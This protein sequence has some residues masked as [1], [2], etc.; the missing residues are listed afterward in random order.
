[1]N[2]LTA[3]KGSMDPMDLRRDELEEY[4]DGDQNGEVSTVR[5]FTVI[6]EQLIKRLFVIVE[7]R[8][9]HGLGMMAKRR[10]KEQFTNEERNV[11]SRWYLR[12]YAY[13]LRTGIPYNGVK[14]SIGTYQTLCKFA[15]FYATN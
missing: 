9:G 11:L 10:L 4:L 3:I 14:M 1:M 6:G 7:V 2:L 8:E 5:T 13:M 12:I 15:D